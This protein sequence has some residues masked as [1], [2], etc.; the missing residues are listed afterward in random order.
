MK[1]ERFFY[2]IILSNTKEVVEVDRIQG[3]KIILLLCQEL[4]PK[5]IKVDSEVINVSYIVAIIRQ[6]RRDKSYFEISGLDEEIHIKF[7]N[8]GNNNTKLLDSISVDRN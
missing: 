3:E 8:L 4:R 6:I 2:E 7:S 5:F 1:I